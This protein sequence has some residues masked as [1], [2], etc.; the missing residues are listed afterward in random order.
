MIGKSPVYITLPV[1]IIVEL[2]QILL[3]QETSGIG[4]PVPFLIDRII[5]IHIGISTLKFIVNNPKSLHINIHIII[6]RSGTAVPPWRPGIHFIPQNPVVHLAV[7]WLAGIPLSQKSTDGLKMIRTGSI[8]HIQCISRT[9]SAPCR[10]M[11][12]ILWI[13]SL[14]TV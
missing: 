4:F 2:I 3:R 6:Q 7:I 8:R 9:V 1:H 13:S 14:S 10:R 11:D 5:D 12:Q